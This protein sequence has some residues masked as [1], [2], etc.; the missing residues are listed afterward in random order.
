MTDSPLR[1]AVIDS[2]IVPPHRNEDGMVASRFCCREDFLGFEGHFPGNSILPAMVQLLV[3][4]V[5]TGIPDVQILSMSRAKFTRLVKPGDS[6]DAV[7][8]LSDNEN[9]VSVNVRLTV[10]GEQASS[11]NLVV[12]GEKN[13]G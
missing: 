5:A 11:F 2:I 4:A 7:C 10:D 1:K 12:V 3:G 6:I 9:G 8:A 13:N